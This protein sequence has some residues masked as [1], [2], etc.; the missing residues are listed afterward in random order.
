M[1]KIVEYAP[2]AASVAG[3]ALSV[4]GDLDS[5][6]LA[7]QSAKMQARQLRQNANQEVAAATVAMREEQRKKELTASRAIAVAAASG[8]GTLDPTVVRILQGIE[9]EG[10]LASATQL[11]NGME[12]ARG[13]N[14]QADATEW[15]G[16]MAKR[17]YRSRAMSTAMSG[18]DKFRTTWGS[19]NEKKPDTSKKADYNRSA[20]DFSNIG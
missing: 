8:A 16:K 7:Q 1:D 17:F 9:A 6:R 3:T 18:M 5:G 4:K 14:L 10:E 13:L 12:S 2:Q 20:G 11:Y 15:E 19:Q